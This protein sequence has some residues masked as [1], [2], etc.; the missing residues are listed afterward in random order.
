LSANARGRRSAEIVHPG[1]QESAMGARPGSAPG[2][3]RKRGSACSGREPAQRSGR[4][5]VNE[6]AV[7]AGVRRLVRDSLARQRRAGATAC[8]TTAIPMR[9]LSP[10]R[11]P[12]SRSDLGKKGRLMRMIEKPARMNANNSSILKPPKW[13]VRQTMPARDGQGSARRL[14]TRSVST[15]HHARGKRTGPRTSARPMRRGSGQ[16]RQGPLKPSP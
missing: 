5:P 10:L 4:Q 2:R 1:S 8:N 6:P 13:K 15:G 11:R 3:E 7:E 16:H 9:R 12:P 14:S